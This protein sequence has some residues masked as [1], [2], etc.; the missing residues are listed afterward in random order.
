MATVLHP[1]PFNPV[2]LASPVLPVTEEQKNLV[3][4][5]LNLSSSDSRFSEKAYIAIERVL[6]GG[7]V[8]PP[9]IV[10][11]VPPTVKVGTTN[12]LLRV[13]GTGFL[14]TSVIVANGLIDQVT[15]YVSPTEVT[16]IISGVDVHGP[17]TVQ[18][19][20]RNDNVISNNWALNFIP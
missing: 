8:I 5:V 11:L 7:S 1:E 20:V 3:R 15:T 12:V 10:G 14:N 19:G 13:Q 4:D 16:C 9:V 6:T 2:L 17:V 18:V